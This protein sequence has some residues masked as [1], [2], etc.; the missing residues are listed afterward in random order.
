MDFYDVVEPSNLRKVFL[1]K[2]NINMTITFVENRPYN[3]DLS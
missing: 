1:A 2:N 3:F